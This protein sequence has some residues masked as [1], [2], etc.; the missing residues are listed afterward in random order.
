MERP[1]QRQACYIHQIEQNTQ[2][3]VAPRL[4]NGVELW[5]PFLGMCRRRIKT[6]YGRVSRALYSASALRTFRY[7][8]IIL[9]LII[10]FRYI[11]DTSRYKRI[12]RPPI[13]TFTHLTL[14]LMR[15]LAHLHYQARQ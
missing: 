13:R 10:Y 8:V 7:L 4:P 6:L 15:R 14:Y 5:Q 12:S 9:S 1:G 11:T 3:E 2:R